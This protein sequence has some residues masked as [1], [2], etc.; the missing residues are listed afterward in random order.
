MLTKEQL[1]ELAKFD[2]PTISNAIEF[3]GLHAWTEGFMHHSIRRIIPYGGRRLTGYA[4][5]AKM[6]ATQ[7]PTAEQKKLQA[8]YY[9]KV[10][11]APGPYKVTVIQDIDSDPVGS[12]WGEVQASMHMALGCTGL[13]TNGGVRDLD[14]VEAVGFDYFAS[15]V[16]VS[17]AYAH[18]EAIDCPVCVGGLVVKPG[19]LIHADKHGVLVIPPEVAPR[20]AEACR[21][22][23]WSEEPVI[24]NC[25]KH[26]TDG[27]DMKDFDAWRSEMAAR[28]QESTKKFSL[29]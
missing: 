19:D 9:E 3:F 16:L 27:V 13:V 2:T 4:I 26:F 22:A 8:L 7:P 5:T 12:L 28:R 15:C 14:E 24:K 21:A 10:K 20:L 6:S 1:D 29:K 23:A 25:Q 18:I 11:A 17:H